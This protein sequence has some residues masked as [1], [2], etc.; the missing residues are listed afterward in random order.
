MQI[1]VLCDKNLYVEIP[2]LI[3]KLE[4]DEITITSQ[5]EPSNSNVVPSAPIASRSSNSFYPSA[6]MDD[7]R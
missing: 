4:S 3:G 2:I 7:L 6:P 1:S 5:P